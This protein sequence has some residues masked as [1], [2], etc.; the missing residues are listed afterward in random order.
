MRVFDSRPR[1][2]A[3]PVVVLT[4]GAPALQQNIHRGRRGLPR[5]GCLSSMLVLRRFVFPSV[6]HA[7]VQIYTSNQDY[8]YQTIIT[9]TAYDSTLNYHSFNG[10]LLVDM[11]ANDTAKLKSLING[12]TGNYGTWQATTF[13]AYLVC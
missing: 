12:S 13:S 3:F 2:L 7:S 8:A 4:F 6:A 10:S 1:R 9:P 5:F 11:D